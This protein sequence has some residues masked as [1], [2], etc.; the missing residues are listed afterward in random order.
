MIATDG[1]CKTICS[2]VGFRGGRTV[3][4]ARVYFESFRG[5]RK[6]KQNVGLGTREMIRGTPN[7]GPRLLFRRACW[8]EGILM[9]RA[10]RPTFLRPF[11]ES[12]LQLK[13]SA[14]SSVRV[15]SIF[16]WTRTWLYTSHSL[17]PWMRFG[18]GRRS[19]RER[20]CKCFT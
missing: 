18:C 3:V 16:L 20:L 17:R 11:R 10:D 2:S 15:H 6:T 4:S 14:L 7:V 8:K 12:P 19:L 13:V 5:D 1:G 9:T